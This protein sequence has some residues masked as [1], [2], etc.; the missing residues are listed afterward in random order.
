MGEYFF[1]ITSPSI[2]EYLRDALPDAKVRLISGNYHP[3][4]VINPS[5]DTR[6][7]HLTALLS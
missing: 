1:R 7:L 5:C 2:D 4:Q 6:C 3:A